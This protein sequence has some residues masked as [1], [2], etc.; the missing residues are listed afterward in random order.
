VIIIIA[1][2]IRSEQGT[3]LG[4]AGGD[5]HIKKL[6]EIIQY[7]RKGSSGDSFLVNQEKQMI[8]ASRFESE[9]K[10][11]GLIKDHTSLELVVDTEGVQRALAGESGVAQYRNVLGR[12]VFGAYAPLHAKPW[13]LLIEQDA[14]E[15]LASVYALRNSLVVI[16]AVAALLIAL[17]SLLISRSLSKLMLRHFAAR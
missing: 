11:K 1:V 4:V 10:E 3:I 6:E 14:N 13:A 17:I 7:T 15:A 9:Y 2:P 16:L 8:T 12:E 5:I